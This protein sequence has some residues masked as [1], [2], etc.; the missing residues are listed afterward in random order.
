ML[1]TNDILE[2][3]NEYCYKIQIEYNRFEFTDRTS[4]FWTH[5]RIDKYRFGIIA[6]LLYD[7]DPK[8]IEMLKYQ[9]DER[10][11]YS[12]VD[13]NSYRNGS[14][15]KEKLE[16]Y[17]KSELYKSSTFTLSISEKVYDLVKSRNNIYFEP[18]KY[19]TKNEQLMFLLL[20]LC[21]KKYYEEK[22]RFIEIEQPNLE[23]IVNKKNYN[24]I[25]IND[26]TILIP[27]ICNRIYNKNMNKTIF[28]CIDSSFAKVLYC[29]KNNGYLNKLALKGKNNYIFDG[30]VNTSPLSHQVERGLLFNWDI[31]K[32]PKITK[33][34]NEE[35]YSDNMW[36]Q[37]LDKDMIFEEMLDDEFKQN[38]NIITNVIH[39]AFYKKDNDYL[40]SHMDHEFIFYSIEEYE[41]RK[42][43]YN[44]KGHKK[45]KTFKIDNSAIPM[46]YLCETYN[47]SEKK[48]VPFLYYVLNLYFKNKLLVQE[49]FSIR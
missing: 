43:Q 4:N 39:V 47:N 24:L 48:I 46:N 25:D 22:E 31:E 17:D 40:I 11:L 30:M 6:G 2:E 42:K 18:V 49:Y 9:C 13:L 21:Y 34:Y 36:I 27:E 45:I 1:I 14:K 23:N 19:K 5:E 16:S 41:K 44:Q 29:L 35:R 26:N 7:A 20:Q 15:N 32:L 33:L 12:L 38:N 37:V 10:M 28:C 3:F 8:I